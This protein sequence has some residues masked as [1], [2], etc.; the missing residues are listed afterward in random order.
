MGKRENQR[1]TRKQVAERY[2]VPLRSIDYLVSTR[3]IPFFR[4]GTRAVRFDPERLAKWEK[5]REGVPFR[6]SG[7]SSE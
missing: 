4:F 3:Q 5:E 7:E 2:Q 1:L 6:M